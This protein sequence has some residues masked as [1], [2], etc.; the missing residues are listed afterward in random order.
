MEDF[1]SLKDGIGA[2]A[3][4]TLLFWTALTDA[5]ADAKTASAIIS[6]FLTTVINYGNERE[7]PR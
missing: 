2:V 4:M 5:G 6:I 1:E 7:H 3:E